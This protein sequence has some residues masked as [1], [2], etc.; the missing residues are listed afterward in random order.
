M[1]VYKPI[2]RGVI[3]CPDKEEFE[4]K[5]DPNYG[6]LKNAIN[7]P[8]RNWRKYFETSSIKTGDNRLLLSCRSPLVIF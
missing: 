8:C 1:S 7:V 4:G 2:Q 3:G 5:A 6:T